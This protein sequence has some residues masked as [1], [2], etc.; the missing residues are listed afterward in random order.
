MAALGALT[1]KHSP[2]QGMA[3]PGQQ[4]IRSSATHNRRCGTPSMRLPE[5]PRHEPTDRTRVSRY[6][7]E[8]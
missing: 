4:T 3:E 7:L 8:P 1:G 6:L 2:D 5:T